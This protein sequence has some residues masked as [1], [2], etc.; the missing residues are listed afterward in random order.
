MTFCFGEKF[1]LGE[2]I[3]SGSFGE[4]YLTKNVHN[5]EVLAT[6]LEKITK[7]GSKSQLRRE[8]KIYQLLHGSGK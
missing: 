7:K 8:A 4:I 6:K 1:E 2:R 3:G 5:D